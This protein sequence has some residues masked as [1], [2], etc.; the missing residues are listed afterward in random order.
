M[1]GATKRRTDGCKQIE[2][3]FEISAGRENGYRGFTFKRGITPGKWRVAVETM[4]GQTLGEITF[5]VV[6]SP[7]PPHPLKTDLKR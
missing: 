6:P 1:S 4:R 3:P 7:I 5:D 2:L